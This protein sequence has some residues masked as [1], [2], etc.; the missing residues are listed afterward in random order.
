MMFKT[1]EF[2]ANKFLLEFQ[3]SQLLRDTFVKL[4]KIART[5]GISLNYFDGK[6]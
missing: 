6:F 1:K 4:A 2:N 5:E 3:S